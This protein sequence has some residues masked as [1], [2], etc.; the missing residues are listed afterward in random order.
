MTSA[1]AASAGIVVKGQRADFDEILDP[2]ALEFLADLHRRFDGTRRRP[3]ARAERQ[4]RLDAG[5]IPDFLP[6]TK[7]IREGD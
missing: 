2:Q 5:E 3:G 4:K 6:D 1:V 7:H